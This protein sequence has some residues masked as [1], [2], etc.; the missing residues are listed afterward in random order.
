MEEQLLKRIRS[1]NLGRL[2]TAEIIYL[3]PQPNGSYAVGVTLE[4]KSSSH[5][6][7]IHIA[8]TMLR[9]LANGTRN[10]NLDSLLR[11]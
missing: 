3:I 1:I 8:R 2:K 10:R 7:Q 5:V 4:G 6:S 9:S 11:L